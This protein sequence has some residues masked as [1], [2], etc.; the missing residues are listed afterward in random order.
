MQQIKLGIDN[1][2]YN[3][4]SS[5]RMLYASGFATDANGFITP[6]MQLYYEGM[7]YAMAASA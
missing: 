2:N 7:Y 4:K 3:T 5:D 6:N 1:G